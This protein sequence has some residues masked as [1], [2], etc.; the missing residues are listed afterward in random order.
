MNQKFS[1]LLEHADL[2]EPLLEYYGCKYTVRDE[3]KLFDKF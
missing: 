2:P 3:S 1:L